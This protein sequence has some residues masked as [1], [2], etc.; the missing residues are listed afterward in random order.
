MRSEMD[1]F[2]GGF[3]RVMTMISQSI[4]FRRRRRGEGGECTT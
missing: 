2:A 3:D 4:F 1:E